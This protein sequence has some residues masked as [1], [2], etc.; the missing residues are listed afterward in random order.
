MTD[1]DPS[2]DRIAQLLE[3]INQMDE[4]LRQQAWR[5]YSL[6]QRLGV[7]PPPRPQQPA[8]RPPM[9]SPRPQ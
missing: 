3:R 2:Q 1:E 9:L 8:A 4:M 7:S 5:L 6:E